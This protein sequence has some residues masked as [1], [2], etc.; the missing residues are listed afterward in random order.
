VLFLDAPRITTLLMQMAR[1]RNSTIK[2]GVE[3]RVLGAPERRGV[4]QYLYRLIAELLAISDTEEYHVIVDH[5]I[6]PLNVINHPRFIVRRV[7][8]CRGYRFNTWLHFRLP[9]HILRARYDLVFYPYNV[10]PLL[11]PT[12]SIVAIHDIKIQKSRGSFLGRHG[13]DGGKYLPGALRSAERLILVSEFTRQEAEKDI[14]PLAN[15][16]VVHEGIADIYDRLEMTPSEVETLKKKYGIR[17]RFVMGFGASGTL[18]NVDFLVRSFLRVRRHL[19]GDL[20]L[21]LVGCQEMDS[22]DYFRTVTDNHAEHDVVCVGFVSDRDVVALYNCTDCFVYP[23]L[24]EGFGF[25]PLEAMAC[26]APVLASNISAIPE[27]VGEAA[28]MFD[29]TDSASLDR[30][31]IAFLSRL[32][33]AEY[34]QTVIVKGYQH[35]KGYSW[36]T[37][38]EKTL[39]VF[40]EVLGTSRT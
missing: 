3:A 9:A 23:S 40:R 29:P 31:L 20:Q 32:T 11:H 34:R 8:A 16:V 2:I 37:T 14:G 24:Y 21:L 12:R 22:A 13:S 36:R 7:P 6:N 17:D 19:P 27:I 28:D 35:A 1:A 5:D 15:S 4:A 10:L 30:S 33:N 38:A 26:G 39:R 25:P 18:K